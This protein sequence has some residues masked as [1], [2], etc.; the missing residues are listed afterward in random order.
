M[1]NIKKVIT[2]SFF[3]L[4]FISMQA[5]TKDNE[6]GSKKNTDFLPKAGEFGI[7]V[8]ATPVFNYLGNIFNNTVGNTLDLSSTVLYG[9]YYLSD[10]TA[11]RTALGISSTNN[12]TLDY[13]RDDAAWLTD[14]LSNKQVTDT[15]NIN[16][17]Q[18]FV[19]LAYQKFIGKS[20]I[21]GFYGAQVLCGYNSIKT[22]YTYGNPMS[23]VNPMPSS[24]YAYDASGSRVLQNITVNSFKV[25]CGGI[26]GFEYYVLPKVCIG[27]EISLNLIYTDGKQLST[28]S[29]KV[30][31]DKVVTSDKAISPGN[32][33]ISI[34]TSRFKPNGYQDQLGFYVMFH[35]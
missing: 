1:N 16:N 35:F 19:S 33:D 27:G 31:G 26:V 8:D 24:K 6:T 2:L 9:K 14:P 15:R 5:Q 20:R 13:I 7:G 3:V 4:C 25:G 11:V 17:Q 12:K 28:K 10:E 18:Y 23:E 34:T 29:E 30:V 32:S 21:R 22:N